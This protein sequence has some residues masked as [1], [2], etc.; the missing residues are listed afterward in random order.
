MDVV[1]TLYVLGVL[2]VIVEASV[3]TLERF[4]YF[5]EALWAT[6]LYYRRLWMIPVANRATAE[7]TPPPP[8]RNHIFK[9]LL[10]VMCVVVTTQFHFSLLDPAIRLVQPEF[11]S[12]FL[13]YL[14]TGLVIGRG[15]NLTNSVIEN[16]RKLSP[17]LL[18]NGSNSAETA[19]TSTATADRG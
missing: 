17:L 19:S 12:G 10:A 14:L 1:G 13:G 5:M 9:M 18:R 15:S 7:L 3:K 16:I 6:L 11:A 4:W 8:L 2:S